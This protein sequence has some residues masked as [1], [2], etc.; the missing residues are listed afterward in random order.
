M[1]GAARFRGSFWS[2]PQPGGLPGT[3]L[4]AWVLRHQL[5]GVVQV[6]RFE[7]EDPAQLLFRLGIRAIGDEHLAVL[8]SQ[9]GGIPRGLERFAA[10]KVTVLSKQ[11]FVGEALI[12]E[13]VQLAFGHRLPVLF[14]KVSKAD[15]FHSSSNERRTLLLCIEGKVSNHV[16]C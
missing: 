1:T 15:V 16:M 6:S 4:L 9:C 12:Y 5:D 10:N 14:V 8:P 7:H 13:G 3:C 11:I 2:S